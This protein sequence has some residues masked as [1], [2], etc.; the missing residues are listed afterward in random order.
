MEPRP[1]GS[2]LSINWMWN[3][4][5]ERPFYTYLFYTWVERICLSCFNVGRQ[6]HTVLFVL[7]AGA[8][9]SQC[10]QAPFQRK[11]ECQMV[12]FLFRRPPSSCAIFVS[13]RSF[14]ICI[15][16]VQFES[17]SGR[18]FWN[19]P[20]VFN[21]F[22]FLFLVASRLDEVD[23][24]AKCW[25]EFLKIKIL[26]TRYFVLVDVFVESSKIVVIPCYRIIIIA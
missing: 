15:V 4:N 24:V 8:T 9:E 20:K 14:F 23:S 1:L 5:T 3:S 17:K 26:V 10:A 13:H 16:D 12:L 7:C 19:T 22:R 18:R 2:P 11:I 21:L 6:A 25:T